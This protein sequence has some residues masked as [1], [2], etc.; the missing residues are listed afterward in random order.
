MRTRSR[1][2]GRSRWWVYEHAGEL[3]AV[4]LGSGP[5]PRFGFWP[6]RAD[7]YLK[8]AADLRAPS[9]PPQRAHPRRRR[10]SSGVSA[11][12]A[13]LLPFAKRKEGRLASG[14]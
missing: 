8:A 2:M 11:S 13:E 6:A 10:H 1:R 4:R 5:R 3:G 7:A 9:A 14:R 12:T